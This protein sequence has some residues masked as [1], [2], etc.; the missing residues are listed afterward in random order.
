MNYL[1]MLCMTRDEDPRY[2]EELR[3]WHRGMGVDTFVWLVHRPSVYPHPDFGDRVIDSVQGT[4]AEV[5]QQLISAIKTCDS[6]WVATVDTDEFLVCER[7]L[8]EF[9]AEFEQ[10]D[11]L[12]VHWLLFGS[13]GHK[14]KQ[15]PVTDA[16]RHR[17][18]ADYW[19]NNGVKSIVNPLANVESL[20]PHCFHQVPTVNEKHETYSPAIGEPFTGDRIRM[21]H[22]WTRSRED[23]D[24]KVARVSS[25]VTRSEE[26]WARNERDCSIYDDQPMIIHGYPEL[27][28]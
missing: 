1:T 24:E 21:N 26:E 7:P 14:T 23:W 16:Y 28:E 3:E 15:F 20:S 2:L 4:F 10:H 5:I 25:T 17:S 6:R 27:Q 22:Y 19:L 18:R 13:S 12:A 8:P 11:A 9:L